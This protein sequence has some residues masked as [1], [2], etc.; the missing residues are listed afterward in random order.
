MKN[1]LVLI[2]DS[3]NTICD[4]QIVKARNEVNAFMVYETMFGKIDKTYS[5]NA[6]WI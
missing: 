3:N 4:R 1:F 2:Y 5:W 6:E